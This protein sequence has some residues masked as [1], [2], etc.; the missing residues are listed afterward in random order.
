MVEV[1]ASMLRPEG[2]R[3]GHRITQ[4]TRIPPSQVLPFLPRSGP[5]LPAEGPLSLANIT[6]V[7]SSIPL[8]AMV[9]RIRPTEKSISSM[10]AGYITSMAPCVR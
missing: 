3:P 7:L 8:E 4:G 2:M 1:T 9:S 6:K 5:A 10:H